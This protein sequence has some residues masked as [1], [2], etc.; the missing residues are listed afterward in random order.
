[1]S[2][3]PGQKLGSYAIV[4]PLGA[5]GMGEVW[6]ATDTKLQRDVAIKILPAEVA[7]DTARLARFQREA[8]LLAA[9]NHPNIAAIHGLEEAGGKPFLVLELVAGEDLAER[10]KRGPLPVDE[11]VE[12]A[13]QIAEALEEA[14]ERGVVHR[15][16]KPAN[17]KITPDGKVKILD[18][19]L[20]KAWAGDAASGSAPDLSQSPTLAHTG[21]AAGVILGTAA[22]M[23]PEQARG[24]SVDKRA[25]VWAFGALL[26]ELLTG[27]PLFAGETASDVLAA[28][29]T[30]E[31]DWA[32]LPAATP[33][34]V[35]RLLRRCLERDPRQ[36]LRDIGEARIALAAP[37]AE[38]AAGAD[39][40]AAGP[41]SS[42]W[43]APALL[44]AAGLAFAAGYVA[45][46]PAAAPAPLVGPGTL[47]RQLTFEP[48]L[49]TEPSFSPD[50]NYLAYTANDRSSL[51]V[52]VMPLGGG[53]IRRL[54]STPADEAQPAWSPDGTQIAFTSARDRGGRLRAIL[55]LGAL[56]PF[57]QGQG[58][59]IFL[60]PAAGGPAVTLVEQGS[61][62]AWSPDG[63]WVAFQSDRSGQWDIWA[64]P[65][66]GGEPRPI[67]KDALIDYQP[68]WSPDGKWIAYA[69]VEAQATGL[70]RV[71]ASDGS[72]PPRSIDV[73]GSSA[74]SPAWS[75]DGRYIYFAGGSPNSARLSLSR[76]PFEA[77]GRAAPRIERITLGAAADIDPDVAASGRKIAY[78]GVSYAPDLWL[79]DVR[80][81]A[82]RQL[83]AT[84]CL[85]DY[86][87]LS[88]DGRTLAFFS[89]RT[90]ST[91]LFTLDLAAGLLQ[92]LTAA[93]QTATMPRWSPDGKS[94]AFIR[95]T[96]QA[97]SI[98]IQPV[99][100]LTVRELLTVGRPT[101]LQGP[102]WA[103]DGRAL[104]YTRTEADG[105]TGVHVVDLAG[106]NREVA[107]PEGT[108]M[109]PAWSPDGRRIAFQHEKVG[110]RQIWAVG[111]G[112][113]DAAPL[114]KATQELSHPQWSPRDPDRIL[115]VVDHK[116]LATLSVATGALTPLTHFD[117]STRYVDYPSWAPDGSKV[118]FSMT[119]KVGDLFLLENRA[120]P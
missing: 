107:A 70:L 91:G 90:G 16:L 52:V 80:S 119:R 115:V 34:S 61:Y 111:S 63:K 35:R 9:L 29:L 1:M 21:T 102:Q 4:A 22:Y 112:G 41:R 74:H 37:A 83:T 65:A 84:S 93:D 27:R 8:Q 31:P 19:G 47:V 110:P 94:L 68:A 38:P 64:V 72:S 75:S 33:A 88:P 71:V 86:P 99:G 32:A 89:D 56:S 23:S 95:Q 108:S 62:P 45:R 96:P 3:V 73:G 77:A 120:Q 79:L 58:G 57:V 26:H 60:A 2:L 101:G 81:G 50:A 117:D 13:R 42:R 48:G 82:Q 7:G 40:G 106:S 11:A 59:D 54:A 87:H 113:G 20:A 51:D 36:R 44:A 25:D 98:A 114:S 39:A 24:K 46:R 43:L 17:V 105:R 14:H 97:A 67:T 5:G 92:P 103:P 10:L 49:E 18:F 30:R 104:A 28:V 15:D 100:G 78:G 109:F 6:R 85:E 69:S 55:G 53:Q 76:I 118:Y 12:V 66:S 116:N